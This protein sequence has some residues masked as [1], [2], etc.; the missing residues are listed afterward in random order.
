MA[1]AVA[2]AVEVAVVGL[3]E[4]QGPADHGRLAQGPARGADRAPE[5]P[6]LRAGELQ[7]HPAA[8]RVAGG[9]LQGGDRDASAA[10]AALGAARLRA[11]LLA[12]RR[13]GRGGGRG[14]QGEGG[15]AERAGHPAGEA[16][17]L[18]AAGPTD[19]VPVP[20]APDPGHRSPGV[21]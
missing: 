12:G 15:G 8:V 3:A 11:R 19:S 13:G 5:R 7:L 10:A 17:R 2:V 20:Q 18:Q 1:V 4:P 14:G 21:V 9:Q 6:A 16:R